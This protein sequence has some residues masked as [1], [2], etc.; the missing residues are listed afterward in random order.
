LCRTTTNFPNVHPSHFCSDDA[1]ICFRRS[2]SSKIL[3]A[4]LFSFRSTCSACCILLIFELLVLLYTRKLFFVIPQLTYSPPPQV[5][6]LPF[7]GCPLL[8][9]I[10]TVIFRVFVTSIRSLSKRQ[11]TRD[12]ESAICKWLIKNTLQE[13]RVKLFSYEF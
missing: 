13:E 4:F 8:L 6:G 2:S 5:G 12:Q 10:C 1:S 11:R 3:H 7:V 9:N